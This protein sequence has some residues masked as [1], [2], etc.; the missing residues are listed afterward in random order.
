MFQPVCD[1]SWLEKRAK[2]QKR[3]NKK[4]CFGKWK[5]TSPGG[6]GR[7]KL[8]VSGTVFRVASAL[9]INVPH[10]KLA[11]VANCESEE[12]LLALG[13]FWNPVKQQVHFSIVSR[14]FSHILDLHGGDVKQIHMPAS[15]CPVQFVEELVFWGFSGSQLKPCCFKRWLDCLEELDWDQE[16][17]EDDVQKQKKEKTFCQ[18]P[19]L[20]DLFEKPHSSLGARSITRSSICLLHRPLHLASHPRQPSLLPKPREQ[21][22]RR[23]RTCYMS[24]FTIEFLARLFASP[25]KVEFG[26]NLMNWIDLLAI[27]PYMCY[28]WGN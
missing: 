20:W 17:K 26:K 11:R 13:A 8:W 27:L 24:Y 14:N 4:I 2:K 10:S 7:I 6:N 21:D 9:L 19:W 28:I 25:D 15:F 18:S 1:M 5:T 23:V 12:E 22:C 16:S 3:S